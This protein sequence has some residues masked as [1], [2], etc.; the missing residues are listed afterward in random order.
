[1]SGLTVLLA[2][3]GTGGHVFPAVAVAEQLRQ[4]GHRPI[5]ITDWRGKRMIP[6]EYNR[7]SILAASPYSTKLTTRLKNITKLAFGLLQATLSLCWHRPKVI[8]GFGGY[9][10]VAPV[11]MGRI[12]AI[13]TMLHEQNAYFGRANCFLARYVNRIGL[14]W[15]AT[16]NI[17]SQAAAKTV[18]LGMPVRK[19]FYQINTEGYR[20]PTNQDEIRILIVGGSLGAAVFGSTVPEAI[21]RLPEDIR[22]RL[23]I[24]HQA[25]ENQ[26]NAV[27]QRYD[28]AGISANV[29]RFIDDMAA[30]MATAHLVIGRGGASSVAELVAAGRPA[31][32]VPYPDAMDD[33]QTANAEA[34]VKNGGGWLIPESEMSAGSLAGKIATLITTPEQLSKAAES[35]LDL[36]A[37]EAT[38]LIVDQIIALAKAGGHQ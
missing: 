33:H 14:S 1:M 2:A 9:P 32:L 16:K 19:A 29:S 36:N 31:M 34:V 35:I 38:G 23:N 11:L 7:I 15:Q 8:V 24:T 21:S 28:Q 3:G 17:P 10:A 30:E 4:L 5:F 18:L 22:K 37:H 13:P 12:M 27:C 20:P 6:K 25:R 26:I